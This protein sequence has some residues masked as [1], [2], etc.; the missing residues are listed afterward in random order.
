MD[1]D[2]A[3]VVMLASAVSS[4]M[5]QAM[6]QVICAPHTSAAAVPICFCTSCLAA[7]CACVLALHIMVNFRLHIGCRLACCAVI[8]LCTQCTAHHVQNLNACD[9]TPLQEQHQDL[10]AWN[11]LSLSHDILLASHACFA[12]KHS[13][14][15]TRYVLVDRH[16]IHM[17]EERFNFDETLTGFKWLGHRALEL[18]QA[19]FTPVFAFEEAIGYMFAGSPT[20]IKDKDGIAAAAVFAEMAADLK[21]WGISVSQHLQSLRELYGFFETRASYFTS[22]KPADIRAVFE[23]L[24]KDGNYPKVQQ[25]PLLLPFI[26]VMSGSTMHVWTMLVKSVKKLLIC[27]GGSAL[28]LRTKS[29]NACTTCKPT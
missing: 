16:C 23:R 28:H 24:R 25:Q 15:I 27:L 9:C 2:P 5:L 11:R 6:A 21:Q 8:A 17:Q 3:C 12:G 22:D 18:Q 13:K 7:I 14:H 4:K 1:D 26:H 20:A 10:H 29:Q 19:G